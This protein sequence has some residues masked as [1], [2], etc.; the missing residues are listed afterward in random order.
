MIITL[1]EKMIF[2]YNVIFDEKILIDTCNH[3][4]YV[5]YVNLRLFD[6]LSFLERSINH[7]TVT[8]LIN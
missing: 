1:Q 8:W 7:S 4:I 2:S 6:F 3:L 5:I